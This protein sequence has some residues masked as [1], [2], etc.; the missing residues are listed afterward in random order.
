MKSDGS[1]HFPNNKKSFFNRIP[2]YQLSGLG[3]GFLSTPMGNSKMS[4][5]LNA[6]SAEITGVP[7]TMTMRVPLLEIITR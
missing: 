1:V 5:N 4:F 3:I 2:C 6:D 7:L